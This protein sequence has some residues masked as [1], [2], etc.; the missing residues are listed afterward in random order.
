[1][2]LKEE[3]KKP[4]VETAIDLGGLSKYRILLI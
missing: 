2:N 1:M 4:L 3:S